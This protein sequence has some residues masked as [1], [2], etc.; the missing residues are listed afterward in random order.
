MMRGDSATPDPG[1]K[2]AVRRA[3]IADLARAV[4]QLA[5]AVAETGTG[6][7]EVAAV[8]T[9]VRRLRRR[10]AAARHDGPY[11]GLH[12]QELDLST[13]AG[14]LPLSPIIG[15]CNPSAPEVA[16]SFVDGRVM[17]TTRLTK[18]HVGP[19]GFAHGGIGAMIADQLV[20]VTPYR[21]GLTC[22]TRWMTV[23]YRRPIPLY[24]DIALE[25]WCE[26]VD[27]ARVRAWCTIGHEGGVDLEAEAEMV[28][29]LH[30]TRPGG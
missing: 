21:L 26:P 1:A 20:A 22:V 18:R 13:P 25:A 16:L 15:D 10:L 17:G 28:V 5:D 27:D 6:N 8:A 29:A 19:P 2:R 24:S 11:S 12:G 4:R 14:P 7:E 30:V 23:R 3:A 9:E